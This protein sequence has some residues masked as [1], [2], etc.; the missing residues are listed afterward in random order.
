MNIRQKILDMRWVEPAL[1]LLVAVTICHTI[2]YLLT[3]H[4]LPQPFFYEP[5]DAWMDWFNTAYWAHDEGTYDTWNTVYPPLSFVFLKMVSIGSCYV[6]SEGWPSRDCDWVGAWVMNGWCV[7]NA[8]IFYLTYRK[9]DRRTAIYR[10]FILSFGMPMGD[11][12]ERGNII[13][14]CFTCFVLA[15]G[16]LLKSAKLKWVLAGL[17]INFKVYLIASIVPYMLRRRWRW[18]EGSLAAT[19]IIYAATWGLLGRGSP[20]VLYHNIVNFS[21]GFN[22]TGFLDVWYAATYQPVISLLSGMSSFPVMAI[23]GSDR[24]ELMMI[25]MPALTRLVQATIVFATFAAW[26]RPEA[27][28]TYRLIGLLV[29]LAI[30]SSEPGGYTTVIMIMMTLFEPWKGFGRRVAIV[31]CYI[32]SLQYDIYIDPLNPQLK[33]GFLDNQPIIYQYWITLGPFLRPGFVMLIP[34][35]LSCVTIREVWL[36]IRNQGWRDRFRFRFDLPLFARGGRAPLPGEIDQEP[37]ARPA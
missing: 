18:F 11:A 15:H 9:H 19:I 6:N 36:D 13:L 27:T 31:S 30:V 28:T 22:A 34:F 4:H 10:A 2:W 35:A 5:G 32:L 3:Y 17:A 20:I 23:L 21:T 16:P 14:V 24:I 1:T 33:T 25:V 29:G 26:L 8:I 7:L 37:G 12:W